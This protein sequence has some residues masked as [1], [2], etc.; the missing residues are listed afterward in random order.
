MTSYSEE[1][2]YI[3]LIWIS[4]RVWISIFQSLDSP[5]HPL[6]SCYLLVLLNASAKV[7][8][9]CTSQRG[10]VQY[11]L[12]KFLTWDQTCPIVLHSTN[13]Y[14]NH[15]LMMIFHRLDSTTPS[16][17]HLFIATTDVWRCWFL[18]FHCVIKEV[19][20]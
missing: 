5:M 4:H 14:L 1:N 7:W 9:N 18:T 2:N 17:V 12:I 15:K 13:R 6:C 3:L 16:K 10:G 20:K 8:R 19:N 11:Y